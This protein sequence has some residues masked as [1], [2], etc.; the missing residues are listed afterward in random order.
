MLGARAPMTQRDPSKKEIEAE[1]RR[2]GIT[3]R[4]F[5]ELVRQNRDL[6]TAPDAFAISLG[7]ETWALLKSLPDGAGQD[8][9]IKAFKKA[10]GGAD[11]GA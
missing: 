3:W 5:A 6:D 11:A 2:V 9:F 7:S 4:A 1:F 10:F 8:S